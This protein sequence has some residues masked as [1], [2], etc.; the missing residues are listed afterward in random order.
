[1]LSS[2]NSICSSQKYHPSASG[3]LYRGLLD[4]VLQSRPIIPTNPALLNGRHRTRRAVMLKQALG[5]ALEKFF[6]G[7]R[8]LDDQA[9]I[10]EKWF[11]ASSAASVQAHQLVVAKVESGVTL[12][13]R[14]S[15]SSG[16]ERRREFLHRH[17]SL[18]LRTERSGQSRERKKYS[19][20]VI[21]G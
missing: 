18:L 8:L 16:S 6:R 15:H 5:A 20:E 9:I 2:E 13:V 10:H 17:P 19:G 7:T 4:Q 12:F 11:S 3:L 14:A 21:G 1:M